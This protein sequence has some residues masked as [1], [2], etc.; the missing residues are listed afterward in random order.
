MSSRSDAIDILVEDLALQLLS[1]QA[2][3]DQAATVEDRLEAALEAPMASKRGKQAAVSSGLE[4]QRAL[5]G[6]AGRAS[7]RVQET[8]S[9]VRT[10]EWN[11]RYYLALREKDRAAGGG[12]S[13]GRQKAKTVRAGRTR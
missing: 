6:M 11:L 8:R 10:L 4:I 9:L 3:A 7:E 5:T 13:A 1:A 2:A 12:R